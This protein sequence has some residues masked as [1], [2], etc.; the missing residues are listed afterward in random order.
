MTTSIA[1][2]LFAARPCLRASQ[3]RP[4]PSVYPTTPTSGEEP[5]S[6]NSPC[7]VAASVTSS[8]SVP[9]PTRAVCATGSMATPRMRC[10]ETRMVSS[11][12]AIA[13]ALWPVPCGATFSPASRA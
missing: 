7:G 1:V 3:L 6:G 13:P 5:E 12:E 10:V 8:H 11:S 2:T 9:A 4:P